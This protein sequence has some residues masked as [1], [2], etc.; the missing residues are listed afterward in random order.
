MS[1]SG[2]FHAGKLGRKAHMTCMCSLPEVGCACK[3]RGPANC[4]S[5]C[6]LANQDS[7]AAFSTSDVPSV[8]HLWALPS[9]WQ[10]QT[11]NAGSAHA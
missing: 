9:A 11:G 7:W 8:Q 4:S 3:D 5:F 2:L 6:C 10:G 1:I